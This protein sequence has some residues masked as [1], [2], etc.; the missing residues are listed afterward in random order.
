MNFTLMAVVPELRRDTP[1]CMPEF[2]AERVCIGVMCYDRY[3]VGGR[4]LVCYYYYYY[5]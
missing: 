5:S 3:E 4:A 2:T 1:G